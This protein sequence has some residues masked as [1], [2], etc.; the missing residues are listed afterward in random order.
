MQDVQDVPALDLSR[1]SGEYAD[2]DDDSDDGVDFAET[3]M[4]WRIISGDQ[5]REI[6]VW[7]RETAETMRRRYPGAIVIE[8]R[9][10]ELAAHR[11]VAP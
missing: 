4:C 7:P 8:I 6:V 2:T 11:E 9:F 5:V 1:S 3:G 10:D